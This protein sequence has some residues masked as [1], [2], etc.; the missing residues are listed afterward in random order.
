MALKG[1]MNKVKNC[2]TK[3]SSSKE[4]PLRTSINLNILERIEKLDKYQTIQIKELQ[5]KVSL[6]QKFADL[7]D[8]FPYLRN[9]NRHFSVQ[10]FKIEVWYFE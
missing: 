10:F 9:I 8:P 7:T 5:K 4:T 6:I 2:S 3:K 1:L